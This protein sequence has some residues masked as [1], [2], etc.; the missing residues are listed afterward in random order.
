MS[1]V[2]GYVGF[3]CFDALDAT[4]RVSEVVGGNAMPTGRHRID[5]LSMFLFEHV[6]WCSSMLGSIQTNHI[7]FMCVC[8]SNFIPQ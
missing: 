6:C 4:W 1:C 3:L 2:Y 8:P 5:V 7:I